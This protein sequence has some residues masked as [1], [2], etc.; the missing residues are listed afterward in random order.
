MTIKQIKYMKNKFV[1]GAVEATKKKSVWKLVL[2]SFAAFFVSWLIVFL[3]SPE[4]AEVFG[5]YAWM[6]PAIVS[7]V[8][9]TT[10]Y[11]NLVKKQ[12]E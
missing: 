4:A 7:F 6:I 9:Y 3:A 2:G 12:S 10:E 5:K 11:Y 8:K 1:S